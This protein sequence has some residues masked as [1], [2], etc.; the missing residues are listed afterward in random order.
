MDLLHMR[1][2]VPADDVHEHEHD[3]AHLVLVLEGCY[4]SSATDMPGECPTPALVFN[5]PDTRHRDR[6]AAVGGRFVS[7]ALPRES[8][9]RYAPGRVAQRKARRL[10]I[11]ALAHALSIAAL[12]DGPDTASR[13]DLEAHVDALLLLASRRAREPLRGPPRWLERAR[14]RLASDEPA[15]RLGDIA[16]DCGVHPAQLARAF[17]AFEGC[18]PGQFLRRQRL[19]RVIQRWSVDGLGSLTEAA[20]AAGFY[21][22]A[23]LVRAMRQEAGMTPSQL[24]RL[25]RSV[26]RQAA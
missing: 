20:H 10:D 17:R 1:A 15:A 22:H 24:R 8:W 23:H 5:P 25:L 26:G 4:L 18:T 11:D 3:E 14:E 12:I 2:T 7:I 9:R 21:D 13:L 16:R 6:F 19:Q